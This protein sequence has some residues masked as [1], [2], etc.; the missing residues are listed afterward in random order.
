MANK[1]LP[2]IQ[3]LRQLLRYDPV[4]GRLFWLPRTRSM[5]ASAHHMNTFNTSHANKEAGTID[6]RGY[7]LVGISVNQSRYRLWG[8]RLAWAIHFGEWPNGDVDHINGNPS[9][10][11][12]INLRNVSHAQNMRNRPGNKNSSSRYCGVSWDKQKSKWSADIRIPNPSGEGRGR[13][14]H[15]G[16]YDMEC[17]AAAAYNSAALEHHGEFARLNK[18]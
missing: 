9:D 8:H 6:S 13:K 3:H 1:P 16:R 10:N 4:S 14:K 11:R 17:E 15:L 7:C 12:L 2:T 18:L 5:S